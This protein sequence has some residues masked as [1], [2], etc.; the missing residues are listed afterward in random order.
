MQRKVQSNKMDRINRADGGGWFIGLTG[1]GWRTELTSLG[2]FSQT[3]LLKTRSQ[4]GVQTSPSGSA[5]S[6]VPRMKMSCRWTACPSGTTVQRKKTRTRGGIDKGIHTSPLTDHL[7]FK[8]NPLHKV[9]Q[10]GTSQNQ[11]LMTSVTNP[12][13]DIKKKKIDKLSIGNKVQS[14]FNN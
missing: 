12:G 5:D 7:P 3:I 11:N 1:G 14:V 6:V 2:S 9:I 4:S 8:Q 13:Y 10:L